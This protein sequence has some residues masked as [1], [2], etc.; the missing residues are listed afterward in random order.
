[1]ASQPEDPIREARARAVNSRKPFTTEQ[2]QGFA[3]TW[4]GAVVA[5]GTLLASLVASEMMDKMMAW[6]LFGAGAMLVLFLAFW[7]SYVGRLIER[8]AALADLLEAQRDYEVLLDAVRD[9]RDQAKAALA[10]A[11]MKNGLLSGML[12]LRAAARQ[13]E[14]VDDNA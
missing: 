12:A 9:E 11:D 2:Y 6:R 14:D 1:M 5:I 4:G 8:S 7:F 10:E 3:L 13:S